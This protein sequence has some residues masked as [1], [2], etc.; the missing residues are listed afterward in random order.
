MDQ[1]RESGRISISATKPEGFGKWVFSMATAADV[2][3]SAA[4]AL[5]DAEGRDLI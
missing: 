1:H 4:H 3:R 5:E 2:I